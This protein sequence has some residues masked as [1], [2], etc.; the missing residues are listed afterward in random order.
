MRGSRVQSVVQELKGEKIDIVPYSEDSVKYIC[1]ALSPAKVSK[2]LHVRG[3]TVHGGHRA[4]RPTL[5]RHRQER[6]NVRLAVRL[7]GWKIDVKN[8]TMLQ[9]QA[10][11]G[12]K[13]LLKVPDLDE[14]TAGASLQGRIQECCRPVVGRPEALRPS[15]G[16]M[17][18]RCRDHREAAQVAT[19]KAGDNA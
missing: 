13:S 5:A 17:P 14:E 7:T 15:R 1:S 6:Q 9:K 4:R 10:E 18:R 3:R 2:G 11:E 16:W 19:R 8:E 12:P